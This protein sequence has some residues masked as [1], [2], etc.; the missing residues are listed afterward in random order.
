M[1]N[2]LTSGAHLKVKHTLTNLQLNAVGL[3]KYV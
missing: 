2:P 1:L 3:F